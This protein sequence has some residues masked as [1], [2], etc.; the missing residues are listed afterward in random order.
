V[1]PRHTNRGP[2][3]GGSV[4]A[5]DT[6]D[7]IPATDFTL[8]LDLAC[9]WVVRHMHLAIFGRWPGQRAFHTAHE[10]LTESGLDEFCGCGSG[11]CYEACCYERDFATPPVDRAVEF[12]R[13]FPTADRRVPEEVIAVRRDIWC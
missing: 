6:T 3:I 5:F 12:C 4:C 1:G 13:L 2:D 11:A 8:H 10:R 9:V 7:R